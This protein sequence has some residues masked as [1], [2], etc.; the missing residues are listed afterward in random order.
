MSNY[1]YKYSTGL[2]KKFE[3][4]R[5]DGSSKPG[6]KHEFCD[7]FVL[8]WIHDPFAIP[9]ARAYADACEKM[10]PELASDLRRRASKAENPLKKPCKKKKAITRKELDKVILNLVKNGCNNMLK[11]ISE[12]D[13]LYENNSEAAIRQRV[14]GLIDLGK[15][16]F[17]RDSTFIIPKIDMQG[18][19]CSKCKKGKYR[20]MSLY[21]DWDGKLTC[22][23]C[24]IRV[25]VLQYNK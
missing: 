17:T 18:K 8:D 12:L 13:V 6:G 10:Y 1:S 19:P 2:Y 25:E 21:D 20:E 14:W 5:S 11:I 16:T 3:V 7:Y 9:A 15:I 23:N 24:G 22:D 4:E